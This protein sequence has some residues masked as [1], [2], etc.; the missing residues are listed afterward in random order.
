MVQEGDALPGFEIKNQRGETVSSEGIGDAV[1]YFY[2][3]A[4]TPGCT[5]EACNFRDS[6]SRL[7][8]LD[9]D[10]YGVST[11]SVRDQKSFHEK[12]NLNFELLADEKAEV[13]EKFGVLQE[14][15]FAERTTFVIREGEVE[16]V[17]RQVDPGKHLD[18]L[19]D[20]LT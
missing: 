13:S 10:V 8:G 3:K 7:Q 5:E 11:D 4:D 19:L 6:I 9:L 12:N 14:S 17:F 2:P 18:E 1:I 16:K 20:Y 15:G